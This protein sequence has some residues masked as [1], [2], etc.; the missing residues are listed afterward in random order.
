MGL[1]KLEKEGTL[2]KSQISIFLLYKS[3]ALHNKMRET[4]LENSNLW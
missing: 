1:Q 2:L 3:M 4:M